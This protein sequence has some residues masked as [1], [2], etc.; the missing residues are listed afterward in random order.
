MMQKV[1][2]RMKKSRVLSALMLAGTV[3]MVVYWPEITVTINEVS[4]VFNV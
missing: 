4:I 3:V 2:D 1:V